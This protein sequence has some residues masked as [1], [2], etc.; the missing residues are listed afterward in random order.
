[1][2]RC[3][4]NAG[5]AARSLAETLKVA[6]RRWPLGS[7]SRFRVT[8]TRPSPVRQPPSNRCEQVHSEPGHGA[9]A[10]LSC[11]LGEGELQDAIE[12]GS[13][14]YAVGATIAVRVLSTK[15]L[16]SIESDRLGK[17]RPK[18]IVVELNKTGHFIP[19]AINI[20]SRVHLGMSV[21]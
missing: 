1:M 15:A 9:I 14:R 13:T 12:N 11:A 5:T 3:A 18:E 21:T 16:T 2:S 8:P 6:R 10:V 7:P 19:L 4:L 17:G 20:N